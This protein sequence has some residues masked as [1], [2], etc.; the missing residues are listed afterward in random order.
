MRS[1]LEAIRLTDSLARTACNPEGIVQTSPGLRQVEAHPKMPSL[2]SS[3]HL[4]L[5]GQAPSRATF[6]AWAVPREAYGL[7]RRSSAK[8]EVRA[9]KAPARESFRSLLAKAFGVRGC[10][11]R[12][13]TAPENAAPPLRTLIPEP[14][15]SP[16]LEERAGERR[17]F[18]RF[19]GQGQGYV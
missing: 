2:G 6:A 17:P 7:S 13:P 11:F 10:R 18:S 5:T 9:P 14:A 4:Y 3:G 1:F 15:P 8:A 19:P 12:K 16:P